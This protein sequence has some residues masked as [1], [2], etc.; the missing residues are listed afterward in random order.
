M[1][2]SVHTQQVNEIEE[3]VQMWYSQS[4]LRRT[5]W[6]YTV[7]ALRPNTI[8]YLN[9]SWEIMELLCDY[10]THFMLMGTVLQFVKT[11]GASES[12]RNRSS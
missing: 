11:R 3:T 7:D 6:L 8:I 4:V 1:D 12:L 5:N 9:V 10:A 2:E